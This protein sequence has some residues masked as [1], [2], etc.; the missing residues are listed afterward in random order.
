MLALDHRPRRLSAWCFA[1][2]SLSLSSPLLAASAVSNTPT[3]MHP[4]VSGSASAVTTVPSDDD[5]ATSDSAS[6]AC[7]ERRHDRSIVIRG[8]SPAVTPSN[9]LLPFDQTSAPWIGPPGVVSGPSPSFISGPPAVPPQAPGALPKGPTYQQPFDGGVPGGT[10]LTQPFPSGTSGYGMPY[11]GLGF[12][13]SPPVW[14]P[15]AAAMGKFGNDR[16]NGFGQLM[17]PL[18]QD[19]QS[20]L[21]ADIR[22]RLDDDD[23]REGNFGV[24]L[25]MM[26]DP[27]WIVGAYGFYDLKRTDAGNTFQQ[28]TFGVEAL[29]VPFEARLNGYIPESGTERANS[30]S[31]AQLI[32]NTIFVRG[33]QERAYYGLDGEVGV[34]LAED[35]DGVEL[36]GFVGGYHFNTSASGFPD[37]TGP[38]GRLE[39]RA[40]DLT[41]L[42]PESRLTL[43]VEVQWD[44]VRDTQ[45]AGLARVEIPIGFFG[46]ARKLSRLER[47]M[48][49][50][51][52]RDD[53][54]VTVAQR[55]PSEIG[56][57]P[58]TGRE[59]RNV[60]VFNANVFNE[61]TYKLEDL[62]GLV[63]AV[64]DKIVIADGGAG[65]IKTVSPIQVPNGQLFRGGGFGAITKTG[66]VATFGTRPT[67]ENIN[68]VASTI[69]VENNATVAD[70]NVIG[71]KNG[72]SGNAL[73]NVMIV[74]NH[75]GK[76]AQE[77]FHFSGIL[78]GS[79]VS[80][81]TASG[82]GYDGF[83][84]GN[85]DSS[86]VTGNTASHNGFD[87]EGNV[88][89]LDGSDGFQFTATL[90]NESE[91]SG[92]TAWRNSRDGFRFNLNNST[93]TVSENTAFENDK[94]GFHFDGIATNSTVSKNIASD[95][96]GDGF[97][98][99]HLGDRSKFTDNTASRNTKIGFNVLS[100]TAGS[101]FER[102]TSSDNDDDGFQFDLLDAGSM[103]TG[104]T[105]TNNLNRGYRNTTNN[106]TDANNTANNT[107]T[108]NGSGNTFP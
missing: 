80:G 4:S 36:R 51:I 86:R 5:D 46:G 90:L 25:R 44:K 52:V 75:V 59:L 87:A 98:I 17:I 77:G 67:I 41:W 91:V 82:N 105:A 63:A 73:E 57:D 3:V 39:V 27:F 8:Q 10:I 32:G 11:T 13:N 70:L 48:L 107:G 65:E 60:N 42:G 92:N 78:K 53:D 81:N 104:N 84:F 55:G 68:N 43:G 18:F 22:G 71:G 95:N 31:D 96:K 108:G 38:R 74:G 64:G 61:K 99:D 15:Y 66:A 7:K 62:P 29:S 83:R 49:D 56:I 100:L 47:R 28:G 19:G 24:G 40:Y 6:S 102:N 12:L 2:L 101:M 58:L 97:G 79:K 37:V 76:A 85:L 93:V 45:V 16:S 89:E 94:D 54:V 106:V 50:R 33:G 21:F 103:F 14:Q 23:N 72:I 69:K 35:C 88:K 26:I 30:L 20:L 34:L 9:P 1:A